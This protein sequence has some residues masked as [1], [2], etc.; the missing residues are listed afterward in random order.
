MH[1]WDGFAPPSEAPCLRLVHFDQQ[2]GRAGPLCPL[3]SQSLILSLSKYPHIDMCWEGMRMKEV[4]AS[5][6]AGV[7]RWWSVGSAYSRDP[8]SLGPRPQVRTQEDR[9]TSQR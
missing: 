8:D 3:T 1:I 2:S 5:A 7:R 9:V 4:N 6:L